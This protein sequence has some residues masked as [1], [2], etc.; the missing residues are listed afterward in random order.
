MK[1]KIVFTLEYAKYAMGRHNQPIVIV[2]R[3]LVN[4]FHGQFRRLPRRSL[5]KLMP[6]WYHVRHLLVELCDVLVAGASSR[7]G[8]LGKGEYTFSML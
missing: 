1:V 3:S 6:D 7:V 4:H 5:D 8:N 2:F